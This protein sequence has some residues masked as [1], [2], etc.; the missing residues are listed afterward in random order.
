MTYKYFCCVFEKLL[1][2][3]FTTHFVLNLHSL[4]NCF[5]KCRNTKHPSWE[6]ECDASRRRACSVALQDEC[7]LSGEGWPPRCVLVC[8]PAPVLRASCSWFLVVC[9]EQPVTSARDSHY[10]CSR[11]GF[12]KL[13]ESYL[14][15]GVFIPAGSGARSRGSVSV[16]L[17]SPGVLG[18]A[19]RLKLGDPVSD[20]GWRIGPLGL[21]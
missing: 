1:A 19:Q 7:W 9:P 21:L 20:R 12:H 15:H 6:I 13:E 17:G 18:F 8:A 4:S 16:P 5:N 11:L 2:Q 10:K 3:C 14:P